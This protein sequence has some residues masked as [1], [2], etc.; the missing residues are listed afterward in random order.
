MLADIKMLVISYLNIYMVRAE[1]GR[2]DFLA[3]KYF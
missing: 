1:R 2:A 3:L